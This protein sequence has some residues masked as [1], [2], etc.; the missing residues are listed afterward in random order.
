VALSVDYTTTALVAAVKRRGFIPRGT[1]TSDADILQYAT[2]ELDS[3]IPSLLKS[4]REEYLIAPLDI[5]V[6]SATV[7]CPAR[8]VGTALRTVE[9]LVS[10]F[11]PR[12]LGRIE[13]ERQQNYA[14]TGSEPLGYMLQGNNLI[15][16]PAVTS[17]TLRLTYQQRPGQ[18]VSTTACAKVLNVST[19]VLTVE[20]IPDDFEDSELFDIVSGQPNFVAEGMDLSVDDIDPTGLTITFTD[21]LPSGILAGD[22]VSFAVETCIPQL[23]FELFGLLAQKTAHA[24]ASATGSSREGAIYKK[25]ESVEKEMKALLS[26]RVDGSARVIVNRLGAGARQWVW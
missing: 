12:Q 24:I 20:A 17:G 22:Y 11:R 7:P 1:G 6:I 25:L 2:D 4:I 19:N 3:Y 5:A 26:P 15:L 18:L 14:L 9:W 23:P 16:M 8:A 21:A 10:G 13:P